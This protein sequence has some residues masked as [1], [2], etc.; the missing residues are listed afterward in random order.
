MYFKELPIP[1]NVSVELAG[2]KIKVSGP[3]GS[4]EKELKLG[5]EIKIEKLENRI[6][7]SSEKERRKIKALVGTIAAHI[8]NM[9]KGVTKGFV[10]R[11]KVVYMHFPITVKVE[12]NKVLL[13]N[14]LGERVPRVAKIIGN[15]QV[16][17]E[18]P[19]VIVSGIDLDDVSLTASNIEQACRIK[20]RDRRIFQDGCW[21]VSR[22]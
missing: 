14:F 15:V 8:R 19:E 7:V 22:E 5:R 13:H 1:E 12:G 4:L 2:N 6:K 10:Y 17:V 3:K 21:I 11:L 20:A 9:I 16:K 18:G